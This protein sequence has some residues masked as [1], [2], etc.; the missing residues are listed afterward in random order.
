MNEWMVQAVFN[1]FQDT[2]YDNLE[3]N[4]CEWRVFK[5]LW[6]DVRKSSHLKKLPGCGNTFSRNRPMGHESNNN[7]W[8]PFYSVH[9]FHR[10]LGFLTCPGRVFKITICL[11][12]WTPSFVLSVLHTSMW[13]VL[14]QCKSNT[15]PLLN[16]EWHWQCFVLPTCWV[17]EFI[18]ETHS[19][20][21]RF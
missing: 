14:T 10:F 13:E 17:Q 9:R 15:R 4:K 1:I 16:Y 20:C 3:R 12:V 18:T 5:T 8:S 2:F 11:H 7:Q 21:L 6:T 19:I